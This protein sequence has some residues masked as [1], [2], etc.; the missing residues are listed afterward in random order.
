MAPPSWA[1]GLIVHCISDSTGWARSASR[2]PAIAAAIS[3]A[4]AASAAVTMLSVWTC[5]VE[6]RQTAVTSSRERASGGTSWAD[7][8]TQW[9]A[10][11]GSASATRAMSPTSCR[12]GPADLERP[13]VQ[14]LDAAAV[15]G[16]VDV[17][18]V[19]RQVQPRIAR[20]ERVGGRRG[21]QRRLDERRP[22]P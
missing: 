15:R 6:L 3:I 9:K 16:E 7:T 22:A 13:R 1:S 20:A 8:A 5:L 4:T 12:R 11:S 21:A 19:E 2:P 18:A 10:I 14:D 17:L